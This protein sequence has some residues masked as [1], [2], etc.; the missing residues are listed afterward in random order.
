MS[1][2][3]KKLK[4]LT[5]FQMERSMVKD[6][7][8][9]HHF[10]DDVDKAVR[11]L[12]EEIDLR[13][14]KISDPLASAWRNIGFCP[15]STFLPCWQS[16][17]DGDEDDITDLED[18]FFIRLDDGYVLGAVEIRERIVPGDVLRG[19]IDKECQALAEK[20]QEPATRKQ[21]MEIKDVVVARLLA[22]ALIKPRIVPVLF[23]P[24]SHDPDV[25]DVF[26]FNGSRK[27]AEDITSFI[28]VVFSSF[29]VANFEN[30]LEIPHLELLTSILADPGHY[31]S[32]WS[33]RPAM[34]A[35][36]GHTAHGE[37]TLRGE[38][39]EDNDVVSGLLS[40]QYRVHRLAMKYWP[41]GAV[42]DPNYVVFFSMAANGAISAIKMSEGMLAEADTEE[43][44]E[45]ADFRATSYIYFRALTSLV[46]TLVSASLEL[47]KSSKVSAAKQAAVKTLDENDLL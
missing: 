41:K 22:K 17:I 46:D 34:N 1:K 3:V 24:S 42:D 11:L 44:H 2:I 33:L 31:G 15:V 35:K 10:F 12:N 37:Y 29:P 28:R 40:D 14:A 38:G 8:P 7:Y 5:L 43:S 9:F 20:Q 23:G 45:L 30:T 16:A 6:A 19:A 4:A 18:L 36:L 47:S 26:V 25:Y 27:L 39:L 13:K 32:R 21:R